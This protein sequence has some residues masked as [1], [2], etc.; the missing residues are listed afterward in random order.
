MLA[1]HMLRSAIL[2]MLFAMAGT[3]L[4]ALTY[5]NTKEQIAEAERQALL[6]KLHTVIKTTE[7]NNDIFSDYITVSNPELLGPSPQ[8]N[9]FR[10]RMNDAPV[11]VLITPTAPDGYGG[12]IKL[13]VGIRTSGE[14]AG[15]RVLAHKET[16]GLGDAIE[17]RRSDWIHQFDG[18][19]VDNPDAEGWKVARDRGQFDQLTGA[20][21]SS[22]AV[23]KAVRKTLEYYQS[24]KDELYEKDFKKSESDDKDK[25]KDNSQDKAKNNAKNNAD[26]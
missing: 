26:S 5:E 4:V 14:I 15:V 3:A 6:Q 8:V 12:A 21:I 25:P 16:P 20:T 11:A 24:N 9:V 22:R 7:H 13:L 2:L 18:L 23:V 1:K 19:S 17:E 10:A